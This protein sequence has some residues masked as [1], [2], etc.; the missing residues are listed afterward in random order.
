VFIALLLEIYS[1]F[2][3]EDNPF[4]VHQLGEIV[5]ERE[6]GWIGRANPRAPSQHASYPVAIP[7]SINSD[8]FRDGNWDEKL[9]H[10]SGSHAKKLLLIG[11]SWLYGW[12]SVSSERLTE[13][14]AHR[15]RLANVNAEIFNAGIPAYGASQVRRLLPRLLER[16]KPDIVSLLFCSNDYGDTALPY[17]HRYPST[18]VYKPFYDPQGALV[19]NEVV[20]QRPSLYFRDTFLGRFRLWDAV[21]VFSFAFQDIVYKSRGVPGPKDYPLPIHR[22]DDLVF[23]NNTHSSFN[24]LNTRSCSS[25]ET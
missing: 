14:L 12:A 8:G 9:R 6:D 20:P 17:D 1:R 22:L 3:F 11:D 7:V 5:Y 4:G 21:D 13:S 18:R 16:I 10:A 25:I 23:Q 19:V 2:A 24:R 15:Y